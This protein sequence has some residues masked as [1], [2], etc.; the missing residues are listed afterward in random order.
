V[1]NDIRGNSKRQA[2]DTLRVLL[3]DELRR[4][5]QTSFTAN[6]SDGWTFLWF[7]ATLYGGPN[8]VQFSLSTGLGPFVEARPAS[9]KVSATIAILGND[10]DGTT[11]VKFGGTAAQFKIISGTEITADVPT[12]AKTGYLTVSVPE[13]TLKSNIPFRV[14]Q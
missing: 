13:Q 1:R 9:G 10:L 7:Y 6:P 11:E 5:R 14:E 12:D 8:G 4:R 3:E 2:Y